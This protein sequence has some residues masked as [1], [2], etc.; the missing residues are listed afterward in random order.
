[1]LSEKIDGILLFIILKY[2][3]KPNKKLFVYVSCKIN[4]DSI[5][6]FFT[7]INSL[8]LINKNA[9]NMINKNHI[10]EECIQYSLTNGY[11]DTINIYP[12]IV[13][14]NNYKLHLEKRYSFEINSKTIF[15]KRLADLY[16]LF[17]GIMQNQF[18]PH[19]NKLVRLESIKKRIKHYENYLKIINKR[20]VYILTKLKNF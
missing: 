2:I 1:M 5:W 3:L 19:R 12:K 10:W 20:T 16:N 8:T 6:Q 4:T 18:M 13:C 15:D 9:L 7:Y 14:K 11:C 17:S